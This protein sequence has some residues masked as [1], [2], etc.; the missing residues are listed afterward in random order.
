MTQILTLTMNPA[1]DISTSVDK[2]VPTHK[3][4]CTEE[5]TQ[6]G[7]GGINISRVIR[8]LETATTAIY[9]CGGFTG[10]ILTRLLEQEGVQ[11]HSIPITQETR[12]CFTVHETS[13]GKDF[14][15]LLPGP[16]LNAAEQQACAHAVEKLGGSARFVVASGSLPPGV[17]VD[18]YARLAK[19]AK[20]KGHRF[21]LDTS[22]A[23]LRHALEAGVY[24]FKPSLRELEELLGQTLNSQA[25]WHEAAREIVRRG[26]AEV[27]ALSLGED[28][29]MLVTAEQSFRA[30]AVPVKVV[31]TV[32][33]GDN[34]VAGILWGLCHDQPLQQAFGY[35]MASAAAAV[36]NA[37]SNLCEPD[38]LH[39]LY[40]KVRITQM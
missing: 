2:V 17:E 8:R 35:G 24:L 39:K 38:D 37:H 4:R 22:G 31:S 29:A 7:G 25:E 18:F 1:L 16:A 27:V 23:A 33:A 34:F 9:P 11:S 6:P 12:E 28:G 10:Q 21:V 26:Q 40:E 5:K 3:L 36:M 14:R 30:Q 19:R 15:F 13:S 32:G 20:E